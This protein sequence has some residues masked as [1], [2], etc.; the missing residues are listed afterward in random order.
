MSDA[1]FDINKR[2]PGAFK[3]GKQINQ[4]LRLLWIGCGK[5]NSR[6][7]GHL[8]LLY[9]LKE[10]QIKHEFHSVDGGQEWKVR[11]DQL[12]GFMQKVF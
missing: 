2:V 3:N 7:N 9:T 5:E 4:Q 6:Y 11:R 8:V 10:N 1:N 12:H